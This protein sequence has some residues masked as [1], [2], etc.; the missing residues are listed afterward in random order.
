MKKLYIITGAI[1]HLGTSIIKLLEKEDCLVRGL[2]LPS[3][4][5]VNHNNV[6]YYKGDIRK[7][8][9]LLPLFE[10]AEGME[11]ILIHSAG[12]ISLLPEVTPLI[13]DVNVK[14]T[15]NIISL[16]L[17]KN[18]S[19][20]VY[21]S[22]VDAIPA[23]NKLVVVK[24]IKKFSP[25]KVEGGYAKTKAE[26][27]QAVLDAVK[28]GLKA[29]IVHPSAILGPYD[30]AGTNNV[31]NQVKQYMNGKMPAYVEGDFDFV[32]VR[33]VARGCIL[34]G[35]KGRTG[36]C[37]ILSN[38]CY[39]FK[40]FLDTIKAVSGTGKRIPKLPMWFVMGIAPLM[41]RYGKIKKQPP[42][43]T[44]YT[45]RKLNSNSRF[46]HDKAAIELGYRP[47]D[48]YDTITDTVAWIRKEGNKI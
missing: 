12:I 41:E 18:V 10:E 45:L 27:S 4:N 28:D 35:E 11:V 37:Y 22:S 39:S 16:C 44:K 43:F 34:A 31:V 30:L 48:F 47:M 24:E 3:E 26:A 32:D 7:T 36:E 42:L 15:K 6:T 19:R 17:E 9:T 29:V 5:A 23:N 46:S 2:I 13:Y 33:D 14:G 20:L 8:E 40:E 1:G 25:D 21:V 38:S